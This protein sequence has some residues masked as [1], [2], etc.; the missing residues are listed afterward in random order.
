MRAG[1]FLFVVTRRAGGAAGAVFALRGPVA[2]VVPIG[3]EGILIGGHLMRGCRGRPGERDLRQF[4]R[5][6]FD[7]GRG[8]GAK[9]KRQGCERAESGRSRG[10]PEELQGFGHCADAREFWPLRKSWL[11]LSTMFSPRSMLLDA[12]RDASLERSLR[13]EKFSQCVQGGCRG[14]AV[15]F[16][17]TFEEAGLVHGSKLIQCDLA[18]LVLK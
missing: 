10:A 2:H 12:I 4:V 11:A 5:N 18:R 9:S 13:R 17:Q 14:G 1:P 15:E 7:L 6:A 16:P 8:A 3:I